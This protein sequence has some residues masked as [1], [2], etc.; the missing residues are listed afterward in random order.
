MEFEE[1][2]LTFIK[3]L[4]MKIQREPLSWQEVSDFALGIAKEIDR[5]KVSNEPCLLLERLYQET[6]WLQCE[7]KSQEQ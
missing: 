5:R 4:K 1:K 7:L 3:Y 2:Y 6:V